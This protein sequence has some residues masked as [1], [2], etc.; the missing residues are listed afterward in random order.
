M[1]NNTTKEHLQYWHDLGITNLQS[2]LDIEKTF[3][4]HISYASLVAI[5]I[6]LLFV[7]KIHTIS[8]I[9]CICLLYVSWAFFVVPLICAAIMIYNGA[10]M[11][12]AMNTI[13]A[14]YMMNKNYEECHTIWE[15]MSDKY[16]FKTYASAVI[17]ISSM[18]LALV[19]LLVFFGIN[20]SSVINA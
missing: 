12:D 2:V 8:E 13:A 18:I 6:S 14:V 10:N 1:T 16:A 5:I 19:L 15:E 7:E 20:I 9:K 17:A 4:K 3:I 11:K